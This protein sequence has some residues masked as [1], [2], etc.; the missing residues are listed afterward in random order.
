MWVQHNINAETEYHESVIMNTE[1]NYINKTTDSNEKSPC[2]PGPTGQ[3]VVHACPHQGTGPAQH[4]CCVHDEG[5][6]GG[7]IG[8]VAPPMETANRKAPP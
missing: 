1:C 8:C 7:T 2:G 3:R 6:G 5:N 4:A